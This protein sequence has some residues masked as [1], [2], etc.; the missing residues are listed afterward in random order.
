MDKSEPKGSQFSGAKICVEVDLEKGLSVE[1]N[2]N[3]REWKHRQVMNYEQIP[4]KCKH[5]HDYSHFARDY[6]KARK[7]TSMDAPVAREEQW[8]NQKELRKE[9]ER[10]KSLKVIW[11]T[12]L[13]LPPQTPSKY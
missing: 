7:D 5:Y 6:D 13:L 1:I 3:L 9:K 4:F 2:L 12:T 10:C 8:Q 11:P